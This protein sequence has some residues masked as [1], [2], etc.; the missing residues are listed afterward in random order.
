M[1]KLITLPTGL[2]ILEI[3]DKNSPT[4]TILILVKT[5]SKY[6]TKEISGISHFL[7]HMMF[8]GTKKRPN[9]M[10]I[11]ISIDSIGGIWNA[12]T[13]FEYTGYF[14]KTDK[15]HFN[16]NFDIL[17]DIYLNSIFPKKE[18]EKEKQVIIAEIN[19]GLDDSQHHVGD[20]WHTLLY[21]DQPAGRH[22]I[23]T[24]E[25]VASINQ[26]DFFK[27]LN[28]HYTAK[29]TLIVISGSYGSNDILKIKK[30]FSKINQK[31]PKE[32]LAV[33]EI[34]K[35]SESL[36]YNKKTDQTH[37]I[38]GVRGYSFLNP[39]FYVQDL[40]SVILGHGA[41]SRMFDQIREQRGLAYY[42]YTD[43]DKF[44]DHGYLA[45]VAGVH[46]DKVMEAVQ[47]ILKEY[48]K[49]SEKSVSFSELKKA[50]E[51]MKGRLAMSLEKSDEKAF[52]YG[53]QEINK[54]KIL[55]PN[56]INNRISEITP[57]QIMAVSRDIFKNQNLN[58]SLVGPFKD[59]NK[60]AKILKL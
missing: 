7:E 48:K 22:I 4:I 53:M 24:K 47:L 38:L 52:F 28:E 27:Y 26:S 16:L 60:F 50:K 36:I 3:L 13:S 37:F 51:F 42:V 41:S 12:Y 15:K 54:G 46:N 2:R 31:E 1:H 9:P 23:G 25:T 14:I 39:K 32:K 18:I 20:L 30:T 34:Q 56:E 49:I 55:T 40:L 8:K 10:D 43:S 59:K 6:E 33:K 35:K 21:G 44:S 58:L 45:T 11:K 5:G 57:S 29:N 17:S 19:M